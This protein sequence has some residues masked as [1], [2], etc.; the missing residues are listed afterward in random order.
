L[1]LVPP[2]GIRVSEDRLT[3]PIKD[4][5]PKNFELL[6]EAHLR[7]HEPSMKSMTIT[8][9]EQHKRPDGSYEID[10]TVRFEV[11]G[12]EFVVLVECK[13]YK[14]P[15]K[16]D[17]PALL[18]EKVRSIGAHKGIVCATSPFQKGAVLYAQQHGISLILFE[19]HSIRAIVKGDAPAPPKNL[20]LGRFVALRPCPDV[21]PEPSDEDT[22]QVSYEEALPPEGDAST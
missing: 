8:H 20:L 17:V 19:E 22:W 1:R 12:V 21:L 4:L 11:L 7:T 14:N 2:A 9:R 5:T 3:V 6:I 15:V 13:R 16:R 10:L 18:Y